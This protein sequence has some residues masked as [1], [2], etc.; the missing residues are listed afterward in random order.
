MHLASYLEMGRVLKEH[1]WG[2][3]NKPLVV[4]DIGSQ[5]IDNQTLSYRRLMP[6]AWSYFGF[7]IS[8]G[9]N[10]DV[11]MGE[12]M[13]PLRTGTVDVVI[14]GQTLEHCRDP[15]KLVKE[16]GRVL[17]SQGWLFLTAP[18]MFPVHEHPV[19]CWR[20]LP[21]G[22]RVLIERAE[23]EVIAAY[24]DVRGAEKSN[25]PN[26]NVYLGAL[27]CWAIGRKANHTN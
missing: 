15:F 24:I 13:I 11:V 8:V 10:V 17:K 21:D 14:S 26:T 9:R 5:I 3:S 2:S 7:D 20:F 1:L 16:M 27:D 12:R 4:V 19:D 22:M 18:M 6:R 23:L 25:T